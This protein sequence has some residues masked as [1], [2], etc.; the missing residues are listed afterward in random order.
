M[1]TSAPLNAI[2][3]D[4][5]GDAPQIR[6]EHHE[7]QE[8]LA[9]ADILSTFE[10]GKG[11]RMIAP[12]SRAV[13]MAAHVIKREAL[14]AALGIPPTAIAFEEP[15][16]RPRL[17]P[18]YADMH[19]SLSHTR[20]A[21]AITFGPRPIGVDI[22]TL[23]RSK[24][25]VAM[26]QRFFGEGEAAAIAADPSGFSFAWRWT[27]KEALKKAADIDLFAALARRMPDVDPHE[28]FTAHGA[29]FRVWRI[30]DAHVC[31]VAE[32]NV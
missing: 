12:A 1:T 17:L 27:A 6:V 16:D 29:R 23:G 9:R 4:A 21:I 26:A 24:D 28:G 32:M 8:I 25:P 2:I 7:M 5:R 22:E 11:A 14:G 15:L 3:V 20:D 18:P 30:G 10:A 13:R 19:V 31:A